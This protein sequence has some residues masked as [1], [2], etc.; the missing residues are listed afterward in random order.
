MYGW[1]AL[2]P[3][4]VYRCNA[5]PAGFPNLPGIYPGLPG[6]PDQNETDGSQAPAGS[7]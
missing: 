7:L 4:P 3:L 2:N 5:D 1:Q 6:V